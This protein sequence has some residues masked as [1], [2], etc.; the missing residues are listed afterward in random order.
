MKLKYLASLFII[1]FLASCGSKKTVVNTKNPGVV[2]VEP[3]PVELPSVN[4]K[5]IVKKLERK[6]KNLNSKTL[7]YIEKYAALAVQEMHKY[8]IP[9][10]ITLAQGILE[11]GNGRS[12]LAT[13]SNNHFG[14]KCHTSWEGERVYHDDD[15]KGECFRK[16]VYVET[17]YNDHSLFLTE[18]KRYAFLFKYGIRDYKSWAY[19]LRKAG[20]ATDRKYPAKLLKIIRDYELYE[21]DKIKKKTFTKEIK[22]LNHGDLPKDP[23]VITKPDSFHIVEKGETLYSISRK[24]N[25]TVKDLKKINKLKNNTISIGQRLL[26]RK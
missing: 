10:S 24:Y 8:K 18:R 23:E 9:A 26:V 1:A 2:I 15:E 13:K 22:E 19:G 25:M 7:D 20:Y 17:S 16:Y 21:F 5:K 4:E 11:S 3:K 6:N 12:E 14:I